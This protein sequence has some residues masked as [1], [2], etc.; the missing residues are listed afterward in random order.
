MHSRASASRPKKPSCCSVT[1]TQQIRQISIDRL[2]SLLFPFPIC[3]AE[4]ATRHDDTTQCLVS[5]Q[6]AI[7]SSQSSE[8]PSNL[9]FQIDSWYVPHVG[10]RLSPALGC[11]TSS[12]PLCNMGSV[13]LGVGKTD[14]IGRWSRNLICITVLE[15]FVPGVLVGSGTLPVPA[16][17][18]RE[19]SA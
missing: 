8:L 19:D 13:R 1:R 17:S 7:E 5:T 10:L 4:S 15:V 11:P 2:R 14:C 9:A 12:G 18:V 6:A 16:S 3:R